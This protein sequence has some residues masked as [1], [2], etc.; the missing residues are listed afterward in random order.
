MKKGTE[1]RD[2]AREIVKILAKY[3]MT[4]TDAKI[5]L[6]GLDSEMQIQ[7]IQESAD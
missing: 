4:V 2:V 7:S 6:G 5:V 3:E 1:Y